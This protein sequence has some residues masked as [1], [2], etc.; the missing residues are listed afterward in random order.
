[1]R[2]PPSPNPQESAHAQPSEFHQHL[3]KPRSSRQLHRPVDDVERVEV[4]ERARDL[5]RVEARARLRE[6][7]LSLQ[8]EEQLQTNKN[9]CQ[10]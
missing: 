3:S 2:I 5:R 8:V 4:A 9:T 1:M 10:C 6:A 7:P